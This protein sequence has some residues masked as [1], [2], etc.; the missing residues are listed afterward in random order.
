MLGKSLVIISILL[1]AST[2]QALPWDVDMFSQ[3]SLQSNEVVR[4]PAKGTVPLGEIKF[5]MK[6][7]E[8]DGKLANPVKADLNSVW[9]G[10]RLY[11]ANCATCH[12][13]TLDKKGPLAATLPVPNLG[14]DFYKKESDG[15]IF[16]VIH[17][18][19]AVMP[20][21]GYK[22]ST[23]EKWD[24]INYLRVLQGVTENPGL[25]K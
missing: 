13:T 18:G 3:E 14:D 10:Q 21:Y 12:G 5:N 24:I 1:S 15:R 19:G 23:S 9:R 22:F 17:N 16:A 8:A 6:T 25:V 2:A 7:E 20:R 4:A 11:N